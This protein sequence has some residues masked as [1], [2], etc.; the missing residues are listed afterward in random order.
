MIQI[1]KKNQDREVDVASMCEIINP[2]WQWIEAMQLSE[3]GQITL[4]N[5]IYD[6]QFNRL[7]QNT[8]CNFLNRFN[9][10]LRNYDLNNQD[11]LSTFA[12]MLFNKFLKYSDT[13]I[14]PPYFCQCNN[15]LNT[16]D[17]SR[18]MIWDDFIEYNLNLSNVPGF[19]FTDASPNQN[20]IHQVQ[21]Y[22]NQGQIEAKG[23]MKTSRPFAWVTKASEL[24][25]AKNQQSECASLV[26]DRLGLLHFKTGR[27]VEIKYPQLDSIQLNLR[28][29]TVFD[30]H[31]N[32]DSI[33]K[34]MDTEEGWGSTI[35]LDD[36]QEG[37]PEAV[38]CAIE[39]S[40][41]FE[42]EDLGELS[43]LVCSRQS[44]LTRMNSGNELSEALDSI[45]RTLESLFNRC[46]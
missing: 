44:I 14:D 5:L 20:F 19:K 21:I 41:F 23:E 37:L 16:V 46:N 7:S 13:N 35:S 12:P 26:R 6:I 15:Q 30:S 39:F 17:C 33:Y 1:T 3:H 9:E 31:C 4:L 25:R 34:S 29:P 11:D 28:A 8:I 32:S 43:E 2:L 22:W 45:S 27:L 42:I 18:I 36:S 24:E 38:H 40:N 10:F